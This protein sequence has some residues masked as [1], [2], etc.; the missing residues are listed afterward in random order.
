MI[1]ISTFSM[2]NKA[3]EFIDSVAETYLDIFF[4]AENT[5]IQENPLSAQEL[6]LID[7]IGNLIEVKGYKPNGSCVYMEKYTYNNN[8]KLIQEEIFQLNTYK[9]YTYDYDKNNR[10]IE[11]FY[12]ELHGYPLV[13]FLADVI[14]L[15]EAN[16]E[17]DVYLKSIEFYNENDQ[18]VKEITYSS[19]ITENIGNVVETYTCDYDSNGNPLK[20]LKIMDNLSEIKSTFQLNHLYDDK[21]LKTET[22][23][24]FDFGGIIWNIKSMIIRDRDGIIKEIIENQNNSIN[25]KIIRYREKFEYD[26][27][28]NISKIYFFKNNKPKYIIEREIKYQ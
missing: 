3:E 19:N 26:N 5:A 17:E 9:K 1:P 24:R 20:E 13:S 6:H 16:R 4:K 11:S 18:L 2:M 12:S 14:V 8:Q 28:N 23:L 7:K 22:K 27:Y 25:K 21:G 10:I 15:G